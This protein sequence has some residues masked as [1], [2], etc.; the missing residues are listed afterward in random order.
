MLGKNMSFKIFLYGISNRHRKVKQS[1]QNWIGL[2]IELF[3]IY[4]S[5]LNFVTGVFPTDSV[6]RGC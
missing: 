3:Q 2:V 1:S 6:Q 5:F 4:P